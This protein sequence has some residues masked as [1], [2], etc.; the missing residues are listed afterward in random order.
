MLRGPQGTL[1]GKNTT[2]GAI[3]VTTRRPSFTPAT[4][5]EFNY[6]NLG[7]VQA[8]ASITGPLGSQKVAGRLSFSGTQRDGVLLNTR[9][10]GRRRTTSN[11]LG[12]RG[13]LLFAPSDRIAITA[14]VDHTRQ[15]PAGLHAGRRRRRADAAHRQPAVSADRRRPRVHAAELQRVRPADRR[16]HADALLPGSRRQ[17]RSIVDWKLGP[18]RLN[19]T[20]ALALLGLES[21]ERPRLHRPAGH[22]D[23]GRAVEP[24]P[25]D[26]G[27]PLRRR[28]CPRA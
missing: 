15:R 19:S 24:G 2:A 9:H 11:N 17:H 8:K 25:V 14:A 13:Q 23:L 16:R 3:N 10:A 12:V 6:G 18:G 1:F 27:G 28:P 20:T 7:F 5:F 22:D 26:A 21:V 4:D